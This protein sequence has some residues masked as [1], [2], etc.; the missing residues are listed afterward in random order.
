[1]ARTKNPHLAAIKSWETRRKHDGPTQMRND[2]QGEILDFV[3]ITE[4]EMESTVPPKVNFG[5]K[6]NSLIRSL[7][8]GGDRALEARHTPEQLKEMADLRIDQIKHFAHHNMLG[9]T[10]E[11]V[12]RRAEAVRG[13][14]EDSI[15]ESNLLTDVLAKAPA[16]DG[17][18]TRGMSLTT[19]QLAK[20]RVGSILKFDTVSSWT[21]NPNV[22]AAYAHASETN[23]WAFV[24]KGLDGYV[25][26][27]PDEEQGP[28]MPVILRTQSSKSLVSIE[29]HAVEG[30]EDRVLRELINKR[31]SRYRIK[32]KRK[33]SV[34][35]EYNRWHAKERFDVVIIDLE[36][37]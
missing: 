33:A 26:Y 37:M 30:G 5:T 31:G 21:R 20:M 19:E 9:W 27:T 16:Y 3:S 22:A 1:M 12:A 11:K 8:Y 24:K 18:A 15:E 6:G 7:T 34:G 29:Q 28:T 4:A 14:L 10:P 23:G 32:S 36:E 17:E 13:N 2:W 25:E 35:F